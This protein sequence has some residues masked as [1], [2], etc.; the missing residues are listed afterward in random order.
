M[1]WLGSYTDLNTWCNVSVER[2]VKLCVKIQIDIYECLGNKYVG[3]VECMKKYMPDD[4]TSQSIK[5][6]YVCAF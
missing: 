6:Q 2:Y 3:V 1:E 5:T 4:E